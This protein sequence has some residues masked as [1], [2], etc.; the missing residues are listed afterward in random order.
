[1][2]DYI[3]AKCAVCGKVEYPLKYNRRTTC[4]RSANPNCKAAAAEAVALPTHSE[5]VRVRRG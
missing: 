5:E 3:I 1:M 2:G 4:T